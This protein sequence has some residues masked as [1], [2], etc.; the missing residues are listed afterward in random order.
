MAELQRRGEGDLIT[1]NGKKQKV[2]FN[3]FYHDPAKL[4]IE[5]GSLDTEL[6][7]FV[8]LNN[9]E[10]PPELRIPGLEPE[11]NRAL[12]AEYL[13]ILSIKPQSEMVG[14]FTYS[15]PLKFS[16]RWAAET[17]NFKLFLPEIRFG[18]LTDADYDPGKLYA[19]EFNDPQHMFAEIMTEIH[20]NFPA[21]PCFSPGPFKGSFIVRSEIFYRFQE[22]F[23]RIAAYLVSNHHYEK[24]IPVTSPFGKSAISGRSEEQLALDKI[25]STYGAIL[26]RSLAYY[27]GCAFSPGQK[28]KLGRHLLVARTEN[29]ELLAEAAKNSWRNII[30]IAIADSRYAEVVDLWLAKLASLK[31]DNYI[32]VASD[33]KLYDRLKARRINTV[34]R[35]FDGDLETFW[36]YRLEI[37]YSLIKAGIDVIHSDPDA[38]W[39]E[40]PM[41][42]YFSDV[43]FDILASQ[44]TVHP[45]DILERWGFVLCCGLI[46]YRSSTAVLDF[47]TRLIERSRELK[48]DQRA[49]N[50]LLDELGVEWEKKK[51][52][53][54]LT[55]NGRDFHC[56]REILSGQCADMK[57]GVLPHA[58]FQRYYEHIKPYVAHLISDKE[59]DS[60]LDSFAMIN[61]YPAVKSATLSTITF[62]NTK[63]QTPSNLVWLASYP[64]SGNTMLRIILNHNFGLNSS[65]IHGNDPNDIGKISEVA[66]VV[67]QEDIDWSFLGKHFLKLQP[68][69][70]KLMDPFRYGCSSLNLV[71]THS[72]YH[73]GFSQDRV[74]YIYR[75]G[76]AALRSHA[77]YQNKF[78]KR[79][80]SRHFRWF[81]SDFEKEAEALDELLCCG[82]IISG[83]WSEHALSWL[84]HPAER[85][86]FLKFEEVVSDFSRTIDRIS[87]FLGVAPVREDMITFKQLNTI[88]ADFFRK[89]EKKSWQ[90]M[91]D[92]VHNAL[93]WALN[94]EAM[95]KLGYE[96]AKSPLCAMLPPGDNSI[97]CMQPSGITV[98]G[99]NLEAFDNLLRQCAALFAT[100]LDYLPNVN[101]SAVTRRFGTAHLFF[102][103]Y[104]ANYGSG[105]RYPWLEDWDKICAHRFFNEEGDGASYAYLPAV[106]VKDPTSLGTVKEAAYA[107]EQKD[108][109]REI[110]TREVAVTADT[111]SLSKIEKELD[112]GRVDGYYR[113][114]FFTMAKTFY[115]TTTVT[116]TCVGLEETILSVVSQRGNFNIRYH[117]ED[118]SA[119]GKAVAL[120]RRWEELLSRDNDHV[121]CL[122]VHFTW[123]ALPCAEAEEDETL[124]R[125][126]NSMDIPSFAFIGVLPVSE[127]LEQGALESLFAVDERHPEIM[128]VGGAATPAEV[129]SMDM[130]EL[131]LEPLDVID[132]S[133]PPFAGGVFFRKAL[134]FKALRFARGN[135]V[136]GREVWV[137]AFAR[138]A[139]C[140]RLKRPLVAVNVLETDEGVNYES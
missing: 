79:S 11:V 20:K 61:N 101:R 78:R 10:L 44:G 68:E 124:T 120:L 88:N 95:L 77:S 54:T 102:R 18:Y 129:L 51:A 58:L 90:D 104:F 80:E 65:S 86:L 133:L 47:F 24:I 28:V 60:K 5:T 119:E 29:D 16:T 134:W 43:P 67:G 55:Y 45:H 76:R 82:A 140:R 27:L 106:H 92:P 8:N 39:I 64:R 7:T 127:S 59:Q 97:F 22:W 70:Y 69:D 96:E 49:L 35:P 19:P 31:I 115:L 6:F 87:D 23:M 25:R 50:L 53:Y 114:V 126:I 107:R 89:G 103:K 15:I 99:D 110:Q 57:L 71:K 98:D 113:G 66:A 12:Y 72:S 91:F 109:S 14:C 32:V 62:S 132:G 48:E 105:R 3:I 63:E 108:A 131:E 37:I 33:R 74:I 137:R 112:S 83:P 26:E 73:H 41:E 116:S 21:G 118:S 30:I 85:M 38:F 42:E 94:H 46:Y 117:V 122:G 93:F 40:N 135:K 139:A 81:S 128:W 84:R 36:T 123:T 4:T 56:F 130:T 17:G 111:V 138:H 9:L 13:G 75:D 121:R 1:L 52:D 136:G 2:H 34:Y 100:Y 125:V